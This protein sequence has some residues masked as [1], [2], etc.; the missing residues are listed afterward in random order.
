MIDSELEKN[1]NGLKSAARRLRRFSTDDKNRVLNLVADRLQKEK[2]E[3]L[4]ANRA[5]LARLANETQPTGSQKPT[6]AFKDRLTLD[7]SRI[8]QMAESIRAVARLPD[9]VGETVESRVLQNGLKI[10][11]VLSPLGSILMIFESRPNVITE[12][13]ALAFKSGNTV[14]LRGGSDS[15]ET[16]SCLYRII[17]HVLSA[18]INSETGSMIAIPFVGIEDYDRGLVGRLLQ[19]SDL[20]D[21]CIPRGGSELI[22]RVTNEAMMPVIK[23]DKGVCHLDAHENADL[24]MVTKIALNAKTQRPGVCNSMETLLVDRTIAR[25]LFLKLVPAFAAKGVQFVACDES[26]ELLQKIAK[27]DLIESKWMSSVT[28]AEETDFSKEYLDLKMNIKIVDGLDTAVFHISRFGS[29]HS[30]TIVTQ[31]EATARRF[32]T[33]VDSACVYWNASTRF[34]DGFE[35]GLGGEI[36]ISTQKLHVRGPVGLRELTSARWL[37]DGTGQIR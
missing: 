32:Q 10:R 20:F 21:V 3:I 31:D 18:E 37:I 9:P 11:R 35:L 13:F 8:D 14:A 25:N 30:E 1:L 6:S 27:T 19:R 7:S 23:N 33:D 26:Y 2:D 28:L 17:H 15:R 29:D 12:V 4:A 34:T 36:G 16:S 24:E 5:D 22:D